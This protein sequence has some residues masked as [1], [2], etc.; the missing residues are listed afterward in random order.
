MD[1]LIVTLTLPNQ[2]LNYCWV[3]LQS[4]EGSTQQ[5]PFG[6]VN[7]LGG[8]HKILSGKHLGS[9]PTDKTFCTV[10]TATLTFLSAYTTECIFGEAPLPTELQV[11]ITN[12]IIFP[13]HTLDIMGKQPCACGCGHRVTRNLNYNI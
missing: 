4:M 11:W 3:K 8:S 1:V 7:Y 5:T 6:Q 12:H 2:T 10:K 9:T 13:Q